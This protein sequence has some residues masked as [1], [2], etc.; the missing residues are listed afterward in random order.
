MYRVSTSCKLLIIL[1]MTEF[2]NFCPKHELGFKENS[3]WSFIKPK[4]NV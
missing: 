3:V 4:I 1:S 2:S